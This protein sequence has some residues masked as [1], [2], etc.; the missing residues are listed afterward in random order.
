MK[1]FR[2]I[3]LLLFF[4]STVALGQTNQEVG[5][6]KNTVYAELAGAG[7]TYSINYDRRI[8]ENISVRGGAN[9]APTLVAPGFG[10]IGQSSY[11]IGKDGEYL[12]LGIGL[13]YVFS[14]DPNVVPFSDDEQ[15]KGSLINSFIGF[16]SQQVGEPVFFRFGITPFYSFFTD[17]LIWSGGLSFGYSF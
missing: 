14:E 2:N 5:F 8:S 12:E 3:F 15:I 1:L 7:I 11:L 9:Y 4:S 13:T 6:S 17:K 10:L 16:R